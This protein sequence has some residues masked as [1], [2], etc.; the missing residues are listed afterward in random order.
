MKF[1]DIFLTGTD[2]GIGKT[3][4]GCG[5]AAALH[6]RGYAVGVFKPAETGCST[7]VEG[8]R[9]PADAALLRYF[10]ECRVAMETVCPYALS[11][12]LAPMVAAEREGVI[13][14]MTRIS[15]CHDAIAAAHDV[16]LIEG[17]GG[18]LVPLTGS[19]TFAEV[20]AQLRTGVLV[21]VGSRLGA[22]NHALLTV[23]YAQSLGLRVLGYVVNFLRA[24]TD[25]AAETNVDVLRRWLGPPLGVIPY[26][27]TVE[28]TDGTR[29]RLA[30]LF[31]DRIPPQKLLLPA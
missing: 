8:H 5:I 1:K 12:P 20:A 30:E 21:V 26:L 31:A 29:H 7:D 11:E 10:A 17:A 19:L 18:L 22:I 24:D 9:Q 16:T 27:G 4:V 2:T 28:M 15:A 13:I 14:D 23:R 3:T 6:Q 25:L